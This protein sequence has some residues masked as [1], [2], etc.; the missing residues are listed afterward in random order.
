MNFFFYGHSPPSADL[1]KAVVSYNQKYV[2]RVL[3]KLSVL[4]LPRKSVVKLTDRLGITIAID[5]DVN[6]KLTQREIIW[7][8]TFV[9]IPIFFKFT[10]KMG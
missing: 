1:R 7:E 9:I 2:H 10:V 3:A 8:F 4:S 5:W 6:H